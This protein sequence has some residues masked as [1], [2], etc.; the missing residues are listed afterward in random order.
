MKEK[1]KLSTLNFLMMVDLYCYSCQPSLLQENF[2]QS[3]GFVPNA[4]IRISAGSKVD[5][6]Q[7]FDYVGTKKNLVIVAQAVEEHLIKWIGMQ[8]QVLNMKF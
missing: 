5:V 6:S 3:P 2:G 4:K 1:T 7:L 8:L